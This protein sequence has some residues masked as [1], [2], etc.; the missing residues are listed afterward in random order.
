MLFIGF[1]ILPYPLEPQP[2]TSIE[3]TKPYAKPTNQITYKLHTNNNTLWVKHAT[4][5]NHATL[6]FQS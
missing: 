6:H 3:H 4:H 5:Q 2:I 1:S